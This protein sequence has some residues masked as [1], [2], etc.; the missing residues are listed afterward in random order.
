MDETYPRRSLS[1]RRLLGLLAVSAAPL[2]AACS[3]LAPAPAAKP[4]EA[5]KPAA[6]APTTAPAAAKP[7]EAPAAA[8]PT[9]A[10]V[11][12]TTAAA[13][14]KP[15]TAPAPAAAAGEIQV[16]TRLGS[17][18]EIMTKSVTDFTAQTGIKA[19]HIAYPA[20]PE[21]W[22]KVQAL[23]AT[24]QV[25]DVIWASLG[26]L[27]NFANRGLLAELDPLIK[28]DNYDM[29]DY[30]PNGLK[31]CSLNGKLYAM[32]WGGHPGNGGLLYNID[33]LEKAGVKPPDSTW[34]LD[35]LKEAVAKL[36]QQGS[37]RT[38]VF[39][40]ALGQDFLSINNFAGGFG[41]EFIEPPTAGK[42]VTVDSPEMKKTF[43][44]LRDFYVNK[45][46]PT[47]GPDV[48][49]DNLFASGRVALVQTGYWAHFAPGDKAIAGKFKW[50]LDLIPKGPTGKSG[51]SL[52]INGQ[53]V[54]AISTKQK[55]A[56]QFLKWLMDPKNHVPIVL[57]GGSRP[58][59]RN[60]VLDNEQLNKDL[61]AHKRFVEAL[62]TAD[63]WKEPANFRWPEFST[64][65]GQVF[66]DVW[67]GKKTVDEVLPEA[68]SKLQAVL[69][70]PAID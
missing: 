27:H 45:Q 18:A 12:P 46:A 43:N 54:S 24:K 7:T 36:T 21:Y 34:T 9:A 67:T 35:T 26:N 48:N 61:R 6:A 39:G 31:S 23:H 20:E 30:V 33:L 37:G 25:A 64:T 4:T 59:L 62:K 13:A 49:N 2:A 50:G 57:A 14:A 5:P 28:A 11:A 10:A 63:P 55:E 40:I 3:G 65:V 70:K 53:T 58:A 32:P 38:E 56:W 15:T 41:G 19:T 66:A 29:G 42:T 16:A 44:Y 69:D 17:D 1:R 68:K 51:T 52:T 22:A 8:K 47:P 60:S